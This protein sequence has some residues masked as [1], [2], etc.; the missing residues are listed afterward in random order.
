M[1]IH[2]QFFVLST[3]YVEGSLPPRFEASNRKPTPAC[4]SDGVLVLDGRRCITNLCKVAR[5]HAENSGKFVAFQLH[6]GP[7]FSRSVPATPVYSL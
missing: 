6:R 5:T 4:G 7:S 2:A 1:K 3:G